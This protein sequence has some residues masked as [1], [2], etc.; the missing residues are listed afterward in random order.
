[1]AK[2]F[3]SYHGHEIED[4]GSVTSPEF[5]Q[6]CKD[7]KAYLKKGFANRGIEMTE[8]RAGHYDFS[9]F[10]RK[11]GRCVYFSYSV[12]RG[13]PLDFTRRDALQG[14]LYRLAK[15]EKDYRGEQNHFTNF[16]DF[17]EDVDCLFER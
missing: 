14:V 16:A 10:C 2:A 13:L 6:F 1:M 11:N 17:F 3:L 9:G 7:A 8:F 5:K 15:D 12:S 4:W